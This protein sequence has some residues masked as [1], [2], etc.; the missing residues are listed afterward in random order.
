MF[1]CEGERVFVELFSRVVLEKEREG[2]GVAGLLYV[3]FWRRRKRVLRDCTRCFLA[4]NKRE[5]ER[6][7]TGL[8]YAG[9]DLIGVF[10]ALQI[11]T[12]MSSGMTL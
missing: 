3:F 4:K 6:G 10:S 8:S 2:E 11:T 5:R 12:R 7:V 1:F 9:S